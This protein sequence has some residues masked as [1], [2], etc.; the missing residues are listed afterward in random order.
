MDLGRKKWLTDYL[1][2]FI[3][4]FE[5]IYDNVD[6]SYL[7]LF[8][9]PVYVETFHQFLNMYQRPN[10]SEIQ[11][12]YYTVFNESQYYDGL[13]CL[14]K[15]LPADI[16]FDNNNQLHK[17]AFMQH[18]QCYFVL[19]SIYEKESNAFME[20]E[21]CMLLPCNCPENMVN[22]YMDSLHYILS[23]ISNNLTIS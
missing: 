7:Y 2:S 13:L 5:M 8:N 16:F 3:S 20:S 12:I 22:A 10:A 19:H 14:N 17:L 23:I 11:D 21:I 4:K 15:L 9:Y 6:L 1:S 18:N